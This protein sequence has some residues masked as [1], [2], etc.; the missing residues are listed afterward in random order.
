MLD[1]PDL[2]LSEMNELEKAD[3][4]LFSEPAV[5]QARKRGR[6]KVFFG[7]AAG[8]GKTHA[9]LQ[10][11]CK[12]RSDN[13]DVVIGFVETH[14]QKETS[15]LAEG[16]EKLPLKLTGNAGIEV[17]ELDIDSALKR[18][19]AVI[20][21]DELAHT[22]GEGCRHTRR[23]QDVRE[24]L[25]AGIDVLTTLNVQHLETL[26]DRVS[27]I[28]RVEV[29]ERVPDSFLEQV[30]EIV[31][32]DLPPDDLLKR[33]DEGKVHA[34][35]SPDAQSESLF[36]K[37]NLIALREMALLFAAERVEDQMRVYRDVH[38]IKSTWP[39]SER[40][41]VGVGAGPNAARLV[42]AGWRIAQAS[43]AEWIV[44]NVETP[45]QAPMSE[46]DRARLMESLRMAAELGAQVVE[47]QGQNVWEEIVRCAQQFNANKIIIGK[48]L[49]SR[50]QEFLRGSIA[51]NLI[52]HSGAIDIYVI[53]GDGF[54]HLLS[55][56]R[57]TS[58][59]APPAPTP[60]LKSAL[61]VVA[62][63]ILARAL[64]SYLDLANI[65]MVYLLGVVI[66]SARYGR[67]PSIIASIASVAA[68]DFFC[69]P[70][71]FSFAVSDTQFIFTFVVMLTV[72]LVISTLTVRMRQQA[73]AARSREQR[74]AALYRMSTQ[75]AS[76]E[77]IVDLYKIGL[78]HICEVFDACAAII[79][80]NPDQKSASIVH[81]S[82]RYLLSD[83]DPGVAEW[84][85][86][87]C[88]V[89]GHGSQTLPG[90]SALYLPLAGTRGNLAVLA[91]KPFEQ[92][93]FISSEQIQLLHTFANQLSQSCERAVLAAENEKNKLQM[94]A[95]QLRSSLLSSVSHDLRTPLATITGAASSIIEAPGSL[96]LDACRERAA[97]ILEE[98]VRLNRLV[99]NLLDMTKLQSGTL[100]VKKQW[101]PV[102]EV[103][104]AALTYMDDRLSGR[105]VRTSI[106]P[107]LPLVPV[108]DILIQQVLVNL[109]ENAVKYTPAGS[110]LELSASQ[111]A[112]TIEI[113]LADRGPGVPPESR[114][115]VFEKFYRRD[116][117]A[118][119]GA[120]LGLAIC[121]G[122]IEAH[123][124]KITVE[125]NPGGGALFRF[126][127]PID[128]TVPGRPPEFDEGESHDRS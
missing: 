123:G 104:G 15:A 68:F 50:L 9:M 3:A 66:I 124:G 97:G 45:A 105:Q 34:G 61:V 21:V 55:P 42:R 19:P 35:A 106:P 94:K 49:R 89:A 36:R 75:L 121:R 90:S 5:P 78:K 103:V 87:N 93:K 25:E 60:Y 109:L 54:E 100:Q 32:V 41:L 65:V 63:T 12:L 119:P 120:G 4:V 92:N 110:P 101:L 117:G 98:S 82:G 17:A 81:T 88:K 53:T 28:A 91:I 27:Q 71:Y 74:T 112:Q 116:A 127:I 48:H 126:T 22:N 111:S 57:Q 38:G 8:V 114:V 24:L 64:M 30:D 44:V 128:L 77:D 67:G 80:P 47:L 69:V 85:M 122:I 56:T 39:A 96:D 118:G 62:A 23:W 76:T 10:A 107:E 29:L 73:D 33:L 14:G 86:L 1:L 26:K 83:I 20:L 99:T 43:R 84:V 125:D 113:V 2:Q 37:G 6:L 13:V 18:K 11:A 59:P 58:Q 72:A 115:A 31:L 40:I 70:P 16:L 79:I 52:R 51:D 46:A 95:E 108:D 102:D 7:Y